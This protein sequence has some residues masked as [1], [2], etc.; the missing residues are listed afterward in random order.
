MS[1]LMMVTTYKVIDCF[2][3]G[4]LFAVPE[5]V[6]DE[7]VRSGRDFWCPNGHSQHY[8][9]STVTLLRKEREKSARMQA[10]LDQE[11]AES[12]AQARRAAAARGQVTKIRNRVA[13]GVCPCCNRTFADLAAH[14]KTKHP[15]YVQPAS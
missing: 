5:Q 10:R 3:C 7:L 9:E 14:M 2:K 6:N 15:D 13:N 1:N 11:R 8:I 4:A 12:A